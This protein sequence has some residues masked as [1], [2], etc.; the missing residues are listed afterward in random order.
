MID[1][2]QEPQGPQ[3]HWRI[4]LSW[5]HDGH[6]FGKVV[7]LDTAAEAATLRRRYERDLAWLPDNAT[8]WQIDGPTRYVGSHVDDPDRVHETRRQVDAQRRQA[9]QA[10]RRMREG[11]FLGA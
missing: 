7:T 10:L 9:A 11:A 1:E 2:P 6:W 4:T 8:D 5:R 3:P